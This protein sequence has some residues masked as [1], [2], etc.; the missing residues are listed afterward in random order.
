MKGR[1][2]DKGTSAIAAKVL[3]A[4]ILRPPPARRENDVPFP[5]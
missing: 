3:L 5:Y 4:V 1:V 2:F